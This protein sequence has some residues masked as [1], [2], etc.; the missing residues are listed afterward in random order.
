MASAFETGLDSGEPAATVDLSALQG[1]YRVLARLLEPKQV[2]CV[3]K[4]D[5]YGHGAVACARA[6]EEA[7]A[8]A[9]AVSR[10]SEGIALRRAGVRGEI[11]V[12]GGLPRTGLVPVIARLASHLLTPVLQSEEA[13]I[14]L[15]GALEQAGLRLDAHLKIDTGLCRLG[16]APPA[17]RPLLAALREQRYLRVTG[18]CTHLAAPD[19]ITSAAVRLTARQIAAFEE[20]TEHARGTIPGLVLHAEGSAAALQ[21]LV[22][23]ATHV[24]IGKAL[25]GLTPPRPPWPR[26]VGI[27]PVLSLRTT[28]VQV[29][30]VPKGTTVGYGG[31]W[32]ASRRSR[33]ATVA[34]GFGDGYPR[35]LAPRGFMVIRGERAPIAGPIAMDLTVADVTE[36]P[37]VVPGDEVTLVGDGVP[38]WELA[39]AA[40]TSPSRFTACLAPRVRRVLVPSTEP[41]DVHVP[42]SVVSPGISI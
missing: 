34:I 27:R 29:R 30:D 35:A 28:V 25:Y 20:A 10:I 31:T 36:I 26:V 33:L 11:L 38:A 2:I 12:L 16:V 13:V 22:P 24:R 17:L 42:G 15:R 8:T 41:S 32:E 39:A 21:G 23:S 7:G 19:T 9:L 3:L 1:N 4:S 14:A 6:L 18:V 5:A 40:R 37:G